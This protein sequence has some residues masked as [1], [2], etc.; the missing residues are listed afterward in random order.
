MST[1]THQPTTAIEL[2]V[3]VK[4]HGVK[5]L[6]KV[7]LHNPGSDT[8]DRCT[9]LTLDHDGQQQTVGFTLISDAVKTGLLVRIDG[10]VNM[11]QA[12]AL[13][14][15][16]ILVGRELVEPSE[17]GE[18][19]Y[20]DLLGCQV[21]GP[22]DEPLGEVADLFEAGASDVLVVRGD[23]MERMIPL[24]EQWIQEVDLAAKI[25]RVRDAEQWEPYEVK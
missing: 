18:Y 4:P 24:V 14:G 9:E 20:A 21:V 23:G 3:V 8:L 25:I 17:E 11:D 22:E 10:V 15:A 1:E 19:L 7:I 12:E 5:G 6:V 2:G 16:R 13:R